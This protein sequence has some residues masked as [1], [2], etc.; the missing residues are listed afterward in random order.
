[1]DPT[2]QVRAV[3]VGRDGATTEQKLQ[4]CNYLDARREAV[5]LSGRLGVVGH[6]DRALQGLEIRGDFWSVGSP[7]RA[8]AGWEE[9]IRP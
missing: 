6:D 7:T 8:E 2:W 1:M 9:W 4:F 5:C 3:W